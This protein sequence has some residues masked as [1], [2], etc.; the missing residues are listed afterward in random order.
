M[1]ILLINLATIERTI[2]KLNN[3]LKVSRCNI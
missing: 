1:K 2:N 3:F